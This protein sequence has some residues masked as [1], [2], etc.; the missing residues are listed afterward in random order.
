MISGPRNVNAMAG[1]RL[2]YPQARSWL[3][4]AGPPYDS[5]ESN[6]LDHP[7][8]LLQ[9]KKWYPDKITINPLDDP[10]TREPV[11]ILTRLAGRL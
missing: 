3:V 6:I 9:E 1:Y 4:N 11:F 2:T 8:D 5:S 10:I 7:I